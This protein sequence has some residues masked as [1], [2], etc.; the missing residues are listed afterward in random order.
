MGG[1]GWIC[2]PLDPPLCNSHVIEMFQLNRGQVSYTVSFKLFPWLQALS[3]CALYIITLYCLFAWCKTF[4]WLSDWI[5][6]TYRKNTG[7]T[8]ET[9][10]MT[11][12]ILFVPGRSNCVIGTR[13]ECMR[14]YRMPITVRPTVVEATTE[15]NRSKGT[16]IIMCYVVRHVISYT[17]RL[18]YSLRS[19]LGR[20]RL[21]LISTRR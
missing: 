7:L 9:W 8:T 10:L 13:S 15:I 16:Q 12:Q 1:H 14:W 17:I 21:T 2:P 19:V 6:S 5:R 18:I 4:F 3:R 11:L 20:Y